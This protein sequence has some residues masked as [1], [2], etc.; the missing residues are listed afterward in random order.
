MTVTDR[1]LRFLL[2]LLPAEFRDDYGREMEIAFRSERE[3]AR[4]ATSLLR[5]W[6]ATLADVVKTAPGEHLDILKRD[7]VYAVRMLSRRPVLTLTATL[8]LALG[9]GAN[10][11]I[12]SVVNGVLFA[13]LPYPDS[14]RVMLVQEDEPD[15]DPGTTGYFSFDTIRAEQQAFDGLA[16]MAGWSAILAGDGKDAERVA[17]AR[18]SWNFF[19]TLG[20][21]PAVGRDFDQSEDHPDRRRVALI[22]D[23]LWRRRFGADPNVVGKPV[24]INQVTY[25]LAGVMPPMVNDLVTTRMFPESEIWSVLGYAPQLPQACRS[26]RH[27]FVVGRMKRGVSITQAEAD[28]TRIYQSLAARFASDYSQPRAVVVSVRDQFLGPVRSTLFLLWGAVGVLLLMTCAN[29]AN[30]LL[31]RASERSDEVTI[32]RALGVSPTRLLRQLLTEAVLLALLGGVA[33]AALAW[34]GTSL[35]AAHGPAAIP[36]LSAIAVDGRV[37]AYAMVISVLTG[38][39][40]GLA[41]ARLLIARNVNVASMSRR[42][43]T[44]PSTWRYRATLITLNVALS[45]VLL[46]GSGLLIRSFMRL[47]TVEP[48]FNP[49]NTL[50]MQLDP[51]GKAFQDNEGITAFYDDLTARLLSLPGVTSVT[52]A[53][54]LPLTNNYDRSGITIEGRPLDNPAAAPEADRYAVRPRY[55]ETMGIPLLR[56]RQLDESD[57]QS[58]A[59]VAVIGQTMAEQLWPNQD[60]VGQRIRVA[61]GPN[62]PM[63]TIVGVVGDVRHY[64]LHLPATLQVYIPHD[65]THYPESMLSVVVRTSGDPLAIAAA[66]RETVRTIDPLQPV[67]NMRSYE[68]IV[69]ASMATRR[70]T[71]VLL[72]VFAGTALLLATI[73]LYGALSY[74]VSQRQREIGVRVAMGA[75]ASDI[76]RLIV[77]QGMRPTLIG[78]MAGVVLSLAIGRTVDALLYG[79]PP[80]DVVTFVAVVAVVCA[81]GLIACLLPARRAVQIDPAMT[82][83]GD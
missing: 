16:A 70:F 8:T 35:L 83:R 61:G 57:R 58:S 38:I 32:R 65:Q 24:Q 36:R 79:V 15:E 47:L 80:T 2:R 5:L 19:R 52:A 31:I 50:T 45:A 4:N 34:W 14:D 1:I 48:G 59:P 11:A 29:I 60:P 43:T 12:F 39:V 51:T 44:T 18:V 71:L 69:S 64:G 63:R 9:I 56:G 62:N 27:I 55:F 72:A 75:V 67:A 76:A 53:T 73:G 23:G 78:L 46:V 22:S 49:S 68:S 25:M 81:S 37:L 77:D 20:V 41:P 40:F 33:G 82:L 17:G 13:P 21:T 6:L 7:L 28:V 74:V 26:C 66:V 42:N 10:T 30:L 3:D 54:Q